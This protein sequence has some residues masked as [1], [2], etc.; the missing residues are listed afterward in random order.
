MYWINN[1]N[2]FK[3][4]KLLSTMLDPLLRPQQRDSGNQL[5]QEHISDTVGVTSIRRKTLWFVKLPLNL[6]RQR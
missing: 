2:K 4:R 6:T 3:P 1:N 5:E